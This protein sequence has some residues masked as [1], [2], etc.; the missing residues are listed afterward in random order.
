[1]CRELFRAVEKLTGVPR[2]LQN[3]SF[4][5]SILN[6]NRLTS[7]YNF[8]KEN[9]MFLSVKGLGGGGITDN[10]NF[11]CKIGIVDKGTII[12]LLLIFRIVQ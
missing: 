8:N 10:G 1:M 3:L 6:P 5:Q 9:T 12:V 4:R 11:K 7:E 2:R